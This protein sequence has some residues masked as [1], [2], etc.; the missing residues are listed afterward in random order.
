[1]NNQAM[2]GMQP[3][4]EG[5]GRV[6]GEGAVRGGTVATDSAFARAGS[7][8]HA[9]PAAGSAR[10]A[11]HASADRP[12]TTTL[13]III[14]QCPGSTQGAWG[15]HRH[16]HV[17]GPTVS[18]HLFFCGSCRQRCRGRHAAPPPQ[19]P[20]ATSTARYTLIP[21]RG[22]WEAQ[23]WVPPG[24]GP[25]PAGRDSGLGHRLGSPPTPP[26]TPHWP[27]KPA[28]PS[29]T[30][31]I[32]PRLHAYM[33]SLWGWPDTWGGADRLTWSCVPKSLESVLGRERNCRH[34][35][36]IRVGRR[37]GGTSVPPIPSKLSERP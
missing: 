16:G 35:A 34:H 20:E 13:C 10:G 28:V 18:A 24:C 25:S 3:N 6:T 17:L 5:M 12:P 36:V 22:V 31:T 4:G 33:S 9:R 30:P 27:T 19:S 26:P 14:Q 8:G 1:M 37:S 29:H 21:Q 2:P 15:F 7:R 11:A 32:H 23:G